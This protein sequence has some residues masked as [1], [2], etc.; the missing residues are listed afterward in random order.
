LEES[1]SKKALIALTFAYAVV[2]LTGCGG[3]DK[4]GPKPPAGNYDIKPLPPPGSPGGEGGKGGGKAPG[5]TPTA[6]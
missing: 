1:M 4:G 2:G 6:G 5:G 3:D